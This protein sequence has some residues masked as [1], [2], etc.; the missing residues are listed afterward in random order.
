[1]YGDVTYMSCVKSHNVI[2][3]Q[4]QNNHNELSLSI[5]NKTSYE[6]KIIL[7]Y[8]QK[9]FYAYDGQQ[10]FY[11]SIQLLTDAYKHKTPYIIILK[12]NNKRSFEDEYSNVIII[13]NDLKKYSCNKIN[14][15]KT[16]NFKI[17]VLYLINLFNK[18]IYTH[19]INQHE[20][21]F[22]QNSTTGA[23][24]FYKPYNG[25][26]YEFDIISMYPS[27]LITNSITQR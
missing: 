19:H 3:L 9:T 10:E 24:I 17:C 21:N 15:R 6:E 2:N 5:K 27:I 11:V 16:G 7:S 14:L 20:G 13:A 23:V 1:M 12:A 8:N 18:T 22:I 4:V 26:A 25:P